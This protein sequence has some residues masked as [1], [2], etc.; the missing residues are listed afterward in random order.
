MKVM[1]IVFFLA[2]CQTLERDAVMNEYW[3]IHETGK[4]CE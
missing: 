2:G 3:C 4:V 1:L